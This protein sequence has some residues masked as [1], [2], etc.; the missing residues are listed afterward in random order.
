MFWGIRFDRG[1][2]RVMLLRLGR[3]RGGKGYGLLSVKWG[4]EG[5][6]KRVLIWWSGGQVWA[7]WSV[8]SL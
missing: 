7:V 8:V 2:G 5:R 3:V 6:G 4:L 1:G